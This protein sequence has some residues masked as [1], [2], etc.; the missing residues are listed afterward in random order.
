MLIGEED[1]DTDPGEQLIHR[2][3]FCKKK[4]SF[5][6]KKHGGLVKMGPQGKG[7]CDKKIAQI[8]TTR[9][10]LSNIAYISPLHKLAVIARESFHALYRKDKPLSLCNAAHGAPLGAYFDENP[11]YP[12][13]FRILA[14]RTFDFWLLEF[15]K[16]RVCT[17]G[18]MTV[19]DLK[20]I[21]IRYRAEIPS[22]F[23]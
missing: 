11:D 23:H 6:M 5:A 22:G 15:L 8:L 3:A 7:F 16:D 2:S 21:L 20:A 4:Y 9:W 1:S 17:G 18:I 19:P 10:L 12:D 13:I 14:H